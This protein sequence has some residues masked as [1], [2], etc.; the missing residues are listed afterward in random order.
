[1][2][3]CSQNKGFTLVELLVV[4]A[5]LAILVAIA[6]PSYNKYKDEADIAADIANESQALDLAK[7]E[8]ALRVRE[9]PNFYRMASAP[10]T[11]GD[12][13]DPST[14]SY[15]R[16]YYY[17]VNNGQGSLELISKWNPNA[18]WDNYSG[19]GT[20]LWCW[21]SIP[22]ADAGYGKCKRH[23][24]KYGYKNAVIVWIDQFGNCYVG[25][26]SS[27]EPNTGISVWSL[28]TGSLG[29]SED[30]LAIRAHIND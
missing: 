13:N 5:V 10:W 8:Y 12:E 16:A 11:W 15:G 7:A 30:A 25:W 18:T 29:S 6:L 19:E 22:D 1:M 9:D 21:A 23:T 26:N 28:T 17:K 20:G 24:S 27:L 2:R 14:A 3:T 4:V